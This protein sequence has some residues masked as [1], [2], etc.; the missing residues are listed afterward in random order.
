MPVKQNKELTIVWTVG[1]GYLSED[2]PQYTQRHPGDIE[3]GNTLAEVEDY[4]I[5][6]V[7]YDFHE[8]ICPL[9]K[10]VTPMAEAL[11]AAC[12]KEYGKDA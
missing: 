3:P 7:Q 6:Q 12:K 1:D 5:D 4:I 11:L 9:I 8:K 10:D 2:R